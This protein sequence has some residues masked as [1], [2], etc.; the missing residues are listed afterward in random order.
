MLL[1]TI[2][3]NLFDINLFTRIAIQLNKTRHIYYNLD[4]KILAEHITIMDKMNNIDILD[5]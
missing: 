4:E 5:I 2:V 1:I 3:R